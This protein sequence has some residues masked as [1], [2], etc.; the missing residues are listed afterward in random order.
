MRSCPS[1]A[2]LSNRLARRLYLNSA[3]TCSNSNI[4]VES[5]IE[6]KTD[7]PTPKPKR[8]N[9]TPETAYKPPYYAN[10]SHIPTKGHHWTHEEFHNE[11][12]R[13]G[14]GARLHDY[15]EM[16][17]LVERAPTIQDKI[18]LVNPYERPWSRFEKTWHRTTHPP[19]SSPRK[20]WCLGELPLS[21][22]CLDFYKY[23]T[24]T[25]IVEKK[26]DGFYKSLN[27]PTEH[28]ESIM[29]EGP[30][31]LN[32][33]FYGLVG[34]DEKV[35]DI[36]TSLFDRALDTAAHNQKRLSEFRVS[37]N[38]PSEAFWIRSGFN[39]LYDEEDIVTGKVEKNYRY[40]SKFTGDDRRKLG[41]L[42]FCLRDKHW[43]QV[44]TSAP[45]PILFPLDDTE[46]TQ[47]LF[48]DS[49]DVEKD[50]LFQ[51]M[52]YNL[53]VD[54]DPLWQC[55]GYF[56]ESGET[57]KHVQF[58][59]KSILPLRKRFEDYYCKYSAPE[60][61][62]P[63]QILLKPEFRGDF[64]DLVKAQAIAS[65]F[66]TLCAEA[67]TN[68]FT[69]YNDVDRPFV[70]QLMLTDGY[71]CYFA[72]AQLNTLAFNIQCEGFDNPRT[73]VVYF[74]GPIPMV[75]EGENEGGK[76][77]GD[78]WSESRAN[79]PF[80]PLLLRQEDLKPNPLPLLRMLQMI[81]WKGQ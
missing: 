41:E 74:E 9:A 34:A 14:S 2:L 5:S 37:Y 48:D 15:F 67:H 79:L 40:L 20:A 75:M 77:R 58:A 1:T 18:D 27:F 38:V 49:V 52:V 45:S 13:D 44:R 8:P 81:L 17:K 12:I 72:I 35:Q 76:S 60:Y 31:F 23:I 66:G 28:L 24:K 22:T 3:A 80:L 78:N 26:L 6:A 62:L 33:I 42:A 65:L 69:Q 19:L 63:L 7:K 54:A 11:G 29:G 10:K 59:I 61:P 39:F 50:V 47:P 16:R 55:P 56:V 46:A 73:N 4:T 30:H 51:P 25:R 32:N 36:F 43:V 71:C 21:Y 70:S 57:K 53:P 64:V 68:G